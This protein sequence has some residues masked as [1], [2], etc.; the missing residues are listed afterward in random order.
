M[1]QRTVDGVK[2]TMAPNKPNRISKLLDNGKRLTVEWCLRSLKG[3]NYPYF[4]ITGSYNGRFGSIHDVILK[5]FPELS[6]IVALHGAAD[7]GI[8]MYAISNGDWFLSKPDSYPVEVVAHHFRVNVEQAKK[9]CKEYSSAPDP[10]IQWVANIVLSMIP[11]WNAEAAAA[12]KKWHIPVV[13][14]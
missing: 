12:I 11:R 7:N 14:S 1:A 5:H 10:R 6:D 13:Y 4:S 9:I 8:P 2:F 3:N